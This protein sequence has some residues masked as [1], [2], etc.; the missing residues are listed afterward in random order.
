MAQNQFSNNQLFIPFVFPIPHYSMG[1]CA[2]MEEFIAQKL[3]ESLGDPNC[4]ERVNMR[5]R[6]NEHGEE[7]EVSTAVVT[8]VAPLGDS[9]TELMNALHAGSAPKIW[10]S[11]RSFWQLRGFRSRTRAPFVARIEYGSGPAPM[12]LSDTEGDEE[13]DEGEVM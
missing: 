2:T 9:V 13:H 3:Q 8:F 11:E 1:D 12:E 4:V 10:Y 7:Q 6:T 5:P